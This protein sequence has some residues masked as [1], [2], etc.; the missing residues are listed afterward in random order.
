M[1]TENENDILLVE[2]YFDQELSAIEVDIV[3]KRLE[4]DTKFKALFD[5]EKAL[6][7]TIRFEGLIRDLEA[8][9]QVER[10]IHQETAVRK[11]ISWSPLYLKIA[12][13]LILM[14]VVTSLMLLLPVHEDS[15]QLFQAYFKPYPNVFEPTMRSTDEVT[16]RAEAFQAYEQGDYQTALIGFKE[17]L[18][19]GNEPGV[20]FLAGNANLKL[21]NV[22]DAKNNFL[23]LIKNYDELDTQ[24]KWFLS[25]CYLKEGDVDQAKMMWEELTGTEISYSNKAKE[26]LKK[27]D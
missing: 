5:Q 2:K 12:A 22:A 24:A 23:T 20:L 10:N 18:K 8:L 14:A 11:T 4:S 27:V 25:L 7:K 19:N 16:Q 9:K 6:I 1:S 21:G 3:N 13:G 26:L 15:E 17:I